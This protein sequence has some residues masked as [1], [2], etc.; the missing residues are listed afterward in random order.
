[1]PIRAEFRH[2]YRTPEWKQARER[3]RDRAGDRCERCGASNGT[4]ITRLIRRGMR[5]L[6]SKRVIIQCGAAHLNNIAGDDRDENLKWLCRGCHLQLDKPF[7]HETRAARKDAA[8][9]LLSTNP[10]PTKEAHL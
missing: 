10:A 2:F 8:R 6:G 1:M 9:P 5:I 7:H 3:C 4:W